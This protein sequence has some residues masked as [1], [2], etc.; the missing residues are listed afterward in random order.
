MRAATCLDYLQ[1]VERIP[2]TA[3]E[4]WRQHLEGLPVQL[5]RK[6][7]DEAA[8]RDRLEARTLC[9]SFKVQFALTP[10]Y[11]GQWMNAI[12]LVWWQTTRQYR[13]SPS[14]AK[15]NP[16]MCAARTRGIMANIAGQRQQL[17]HLFLPS[18][19]RTTPLPAT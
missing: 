11:V 6:M 16:K 18:C 15:Q 12:Q 10:P 2:T 4:E 5:L 8:P 14:S 13:A 17:L 3:D 9:P 1:P 7:V 19:P